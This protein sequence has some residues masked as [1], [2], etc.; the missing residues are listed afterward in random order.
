M[1]SD[2]S[3]NVG[4]I[5]NST[6]IAIGHG[7]V[8]NVTI[9]Q[10]VQGLGDLPT[11]YDG[12]VRNFFE[13]YLGTP[14]RPAPFG[15]RE[16][17]LTAL[18]QWLDDANAPRYLLLAAPA[19]R[20]KS[21]LLAHW[22]A[23]LEQRSDSTR[24]HTVFFPISA[25]F[26]SNRE[27]V[28]FPALY[29][30]IAHLHGDV[31]THAANAHEY[32]NVFMDYVRRPPPDGRRVLILLDGLDEAAGWEAGADLF[33]TEPPHLRVLVAARVLAGDPDWLTRLGWD[34][35]GK[36]RTLSLVGLDRD[37]VRDVL[38]QMGNPL[39]KLATKIDVVAKL[40]ELSEG[41]P[42]LVCLYV[43]ALQSDGT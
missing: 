9:N 18:D 10:I 2:D 43:E 36:A 19:G 4:N 7:A 26:N 14:D 33:P 17:D 25:R 28:V 39:D 38:A 16:A 12:P 20:G 32:R 31:A 35:P 41:D 13:Y 15:G 23:R 21:A 37:G 27:A 5:A 11:R 29:A 34:V 24:V 30:R 8:A 40:H 42:L 3:I 22:V 6:G 1:T